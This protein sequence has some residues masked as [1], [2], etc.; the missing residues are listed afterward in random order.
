MLGTIV[1]TTV[2]TGDTALNKQNKHWWPHGTDILVGLRGDNKQMLFVRWLIFRSAV[3]KSGRK[4]RL[5]M[6]SSFRLGGQEG[7][8]EKGEV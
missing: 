7:L 1:G 8:T 4:T 3:G 5:E 2:G 6:Q